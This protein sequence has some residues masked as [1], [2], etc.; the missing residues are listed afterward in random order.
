MREKLPSVALTHIF[1]VGAAVLATAAR[2]S[3]DPWLGDDLPLVTLFA[4]VA[5]AVWFG[6][7][8]PAIAAV[9]VGYLGCDYLF[10]EPRGSLHFNGRDM[11]GL[12]AY[13]ISCGIII[14]FG[15]GLRRTRRSSP[16]P[17]PPSVAP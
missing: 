7:Y 16:G 4:A 15:E 11:V 1:G 8:G 5:A 17:W 14:A 12:A 10:I 13:L 6:G 9:L 2:W 3:L